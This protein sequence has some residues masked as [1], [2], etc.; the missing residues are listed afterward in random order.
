MSAAESIYLYRHT[1]SDQSRVY[2]VTQLRTDGFH[3]R[4]S[5]STRPVVL[6]V[7]PVTGAAFAYHGRVIARLSFST[8]TILILV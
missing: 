6:K 4:E 1:P 7:V 8:P 3:S 5:A 2:R